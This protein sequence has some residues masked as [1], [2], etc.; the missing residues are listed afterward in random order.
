M[1]RS[2]SKDQETVGYLGPAAQENKILIVCGRGEAGKLQLV[3]NYV[4]ECQADYAGVF[5]VEAGRNRPS[6][7]TSRTWLTRRPQG[8]LRVPNLLCT[9]P[10]NE[11]VAGDEEAWRA[12]R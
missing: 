7:V 10:C 5:W 4:Q 6:S 9:R 2:T 3:L 11:G 8:C 1:A 12:D